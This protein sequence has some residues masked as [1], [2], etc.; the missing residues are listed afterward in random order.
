MGIFDDLPPPA[1]DDEGRPGGR[2]WRLPESEFPQ[3][4]ASGLLLA[5]TDEVA[6]AITAVWAYREGFEFWLK[7]EFRHR[8]PR[9][10]GPDG[11]PYDESLHLGVQFA[12]GRRAVNVG[13]LPSHAGD[14]AAGLILSP[15]SFGG[16]R[17]HQDRSYWVW[18][19]PPAGPV[20]F[21]CRWTDRGIPDRHVEV[22]GQL[23]R[24]AA[25]RSIQLWPSGD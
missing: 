24:D 13:P 2:A 25:A 21:A 23:I 11:A 1:P 12:D 8:N 5:Q 20:T 19:L 6:L 17:R 10:D 16:G 22:E 9:L 15:H 3:A 7:A 18:P 4:A 14:E